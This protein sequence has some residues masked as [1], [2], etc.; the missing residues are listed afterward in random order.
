MT[1]LKIVSDVVC[2]WCY[3]AAANLVRA[4][5]A[6]EGHP[7]AIR[8]RPF[9]LDLTI[10]ARRMDRT[11]YMTRKFGD[12]SRVEGALRRLVEMAG[13]WGST[14]ASSGARPTRSTRTG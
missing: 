6:R 11:E 4:V 3:L 10:P 1:R 13:R 8:W 12:P 2:P 14:F 5:A 7:C 9:Q